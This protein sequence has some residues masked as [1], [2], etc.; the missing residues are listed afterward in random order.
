VSRSKK[1][2]VLTHRPRRIETADVPKLSER[3]A[4]VMESGRSMPVEAKTNPIEEPRLEKMAEPL[5]VLSPPCA[6]E[7]SKPSNI[8]T[9]TPKQ[10]ENG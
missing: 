3:V 9:V 6:M 4:P 2:K 1:V 5:K 10:K 7:L 8:P